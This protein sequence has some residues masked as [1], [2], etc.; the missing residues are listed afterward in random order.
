MLVINISAFSRLCRP[1]LKAYSFN[2][3]QSDS[4]TIFRASDGNYCIYCS[5]YN[6][7]N[8]KMKCRWQVFKTWNLL[9]TIL[10]ESVALNL[11]CFPVFWRRAAKGERKRDGTENVS[12]EL[13][14]FTEL[15]LCA[16][17]NRPSQ[18]L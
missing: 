12:R 1:P 11:F 18:N 4:T 8:L 6:S 14:N 9:L 10:L 15:L 2:A 16:L 7:V 13:L 17:L 3:L 5:K